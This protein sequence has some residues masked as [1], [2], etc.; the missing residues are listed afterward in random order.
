MNK[1]KK[2][3][4]AALACIGLIAMIAGISAC[5]LNKNDGN[6]KGSGGSGTYTDIFGY[7]HPNDAWLTESVI[8]TADE[9][10]YTYDYGIEE[11]FGGSGESGLIDKTLYSLDHDSLW[12]EGGITEGVL[13]YYIY[14]NGQE[15]DFENL[16]ASFKMS[17][18]DGFSVDYTPDFISVYSE[19]TS[20]LDVRF[21]YSYGHYSALTVK[22]SN[23]YSYQHT[24]DG[25]R[26]VLQC[27]IA[28]YFTVENRYRYQGD[29]YF[30]VNVTSPTLE[31]N[32]NSHLCGAKRLNMLSE[33]EN[34]PLAEVGNVSAKY[35]SIDECPDGDVNGVEL[36]D[37]PDMA[38]GKI[39]YMVIDFTLTA[40]N[41]NDGRGALN[42]LIRVPER[43]LMEARLISAPTG[44][45]HETVEDNETFFDASFSVPDRAGASKQVRIIIRL[46]P[47]SNSIVNIEL[48]LHGS[49]CKLSGS[50]LNSFRVQAGTQI[51]K[52]ELNSNG[53][54]YAVVGIWDQYVTEIVIPDTFNGLP[55]TDVKT[56]FGSLTRL[57]SVIIG[58]NVI[59]L[60]SDFIKYSVMLE[61]ITIGEGITQLSGD[62]FSGCYALSKVTINAHITKLSDSIFANLTNLRTV[63][64]PVT[65]IEIGRYCFEGCTALSDIN[66]EAGVTAIGDGAFADC[67]SLSNII[68]PDTLKSI[69]YACFRGCSRLSSIT[70]PQGITELRQE[71]FS[72]CNALAS[73][74]GG[75]NVNS[76]G[77]ACFKDCSLLTSAPFIADVSAI[78][79]SVFEGCNKITEVTIN[80]SVTSIG[81]YAFSGCSKLII[82]A[83]GENVNKVEP[84]AFK[85]CISLKSMPFNSVQNIG[86]SAFEGCTSFTEINI[87]DCCEMV[88]SNAFAGTSSVKKIKIG[89]SFSSDW[90]IVR[91]IFDNTN[92]ESIEVS[93]QNSNYRSEGN[94]LIYDKVVYLCCK[95]SVIPT[96]GVIRISDR[97]FAGVKDLTSITVPENIRET[98]DDIFSGCTGLKTAKVATG[99]NYRMFQSCTGLTSVE[100]IS[101]CSSIS[102]QMFD[103]CTALT[104][105]TIDV[106]V[107][108]IVGQA[109]N[110]CS[111]LTQL[112]YNGTRA[113]W[114]AINLMSGWNSGSSI[115]SVRCSDG[116]VKI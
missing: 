72:G 66:V 108:S 87:P 85:D 22:L 63:K 34:M 15:S 38:E 52:L 64:L 74:A 43:E 93:S 99:S 116:L 59:K 79:D 37:K 115:T 29:L 95:N 78:N 7:E 47:A 31:S 62:M 110:R 8:L 20:A 25:S 97:A 80:S 36:K 104:S 5:G 70:I 41:D 6:D 94:C 57:K 82:V 112:V 24:E 51:L 111:N 67:S 17:Y 55:V 48:Y 49:G 113:Q 54:S 98:G 14:G 107:T 35:V 105:V 12:S 45:L 68:L 4:V 11:I 2:S 73:V 46:T 100:L 75:D 86:N 53:E 28:F 33:M 91:S 65:L 71:T 3:A 23:D 30:D 27:A 50:T 101:G 60:S 89:S 77:D 10:E 1:F 16:E 19:Y 18:V 69:G 109:F 58:N 96:S 106:S 9:Y 90:T 103:G 26:M 42:A 76:L 40:L 21:E 83:G 61:S 88:G 56:S 13:L 84:G 44:N 102:Y 32:T 81:E 39:N 92:L 114:N